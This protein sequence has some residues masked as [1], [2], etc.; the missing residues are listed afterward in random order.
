MPTID[1]F[2]HVTLTVTDV[3]TSVAWYERSLGMRRGP[4]MTGPGWRRTL[5]LAGPGVVLGLQAHERT[6]EGDRFDETRVGLDHVSIACTDRAEVQA[7]LVR[8]DDAGVPH[9]TI[10]AEPAN[11]ATCRD[12]DGIPIEFFAPR[13][14]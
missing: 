14:A 8:L 5:M 6:P 1:A 4:D 3:E 2:S 11:V 13:T 10:S 12:P 9:S 7:W